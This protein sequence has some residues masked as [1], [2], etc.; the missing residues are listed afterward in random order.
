MNAIDVFSVRDLRVRS[1]ALIKDAENGNISLITKHGKPSIIAF[2]FS[3]KLFDLGVN[4]DLALAL[5]EKG[6]ISL[7]KAAKIA[8]LTIEEFLASLT[9]SSAKCMD[10]SAADLD[11]EMKIKL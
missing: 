5:Y 10:Y 11:R 4:K 7:A 6:I 2:P 1:S 3:R 9:D 8:D